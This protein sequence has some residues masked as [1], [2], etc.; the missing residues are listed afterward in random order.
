MVVERRK[1]SRCCRHVNDTSIE[2]FF[3]QKPG[4]E[5]F[6]NFDAGAGM[7][8]GGYGSGGSGAGA[9]LQSLPH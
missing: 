8:E 3:R 7:W 6:Q 1:K 4:I 2:Y 9:R 5:I